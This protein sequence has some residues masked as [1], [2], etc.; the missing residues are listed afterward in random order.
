MVPKMFPPL[1]LAEWRET[2][3]L[4]QGYAQVV[5]NIRRALTPPQRHWFHVCLRTSGLGLSSTPIR[6]ENITFELLLDFSG[7]QLVISTSQGG[8]AE[9]DLD[10]HSALEFYDDIALA[11]T[12]LGIEVKLDRDQ[13]SDTD[14]TYDPDM[15]EDYWQAL[16]QI[17]ITDSPF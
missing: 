13:F 4:I 1:P 12:D 15:V 14:G 17:D 3:D 11:L 2:R 7:H 6:F 10:G 16:S 5:G 8:W 9:V